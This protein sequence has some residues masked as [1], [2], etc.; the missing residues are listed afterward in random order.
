MH[1][2]LSIIGLTFLLVSCGTQKAVVSKT[3]NAKPKQTTTTKST[4]SLTPKPATTTT[5]PK[6]N[7]ETCGQYDFYKVNIGDASKNNNTISY[8]SIVTAAP[9][10]Y[11]VVKTYFPA[12]AQNYRQRFLILHYTALDNDK[13]VSVLSQQSVSSH[14]LV[15]DLNDSEIYQLVDEDKR[16]YHAGVSY[17]RGF[18]QLNDNSIGI[19]IVNMGYTTDSSGKK[20][21]VEFPEWQYKKVA[22]LVKDIVNRYQIPP[23]NLLGH[24]DVAPTRK[25]DPGPTFPWK[26]LYDEYN[27]GMWYDETTKQSFTNE[28]SPEQFLADSSTT[29]F[30]FKYQKMLNQFGFELDANGSIDNAT[31]KTIEAFQYHFRPQQADGIMDIETYAILQALLQKYPR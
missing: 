3:N 29:T 8:G 6:S 2:A 28:I 25:Q 1:K 22:A 13:S 23:T 9:R 12:A 24:S 14:Y 17:W 26:R 31:S 18:Q 7:I 27:L 16:A 10:N 21:F 30:I 11:K 15:N 20:I 5:T 4:T 19:E